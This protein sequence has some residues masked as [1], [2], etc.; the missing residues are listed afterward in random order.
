MYVLW[1]EALVVY[2]F[3]PN[4]VGYVEM[5]DKLFS[6]NS[7]AVVGGHH[8]QIWRRL[9]SWAMMSAHL[10]LLVVR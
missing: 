9:V 6:G 1:N 4:G 3:S 5:L 10:V 2:T 7:A 8:L